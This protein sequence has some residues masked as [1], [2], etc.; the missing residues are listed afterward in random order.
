MLLRSL[1]LSASSGS[2]LLLSSSR[3]LSGPVEV[4]ILLKSRRP[5]SGDDSDSDSESE[6]DS[7]SDDEGS[8][9]YRVLEVALP[10]DC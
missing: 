6:S 9:E 10:D 2:S 1:R 5:G 3:N 7:D 4:G 8:S